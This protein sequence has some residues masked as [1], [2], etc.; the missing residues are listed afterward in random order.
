M[1]TDKEYVDSHGIDKYLDV[2]AV[3]LNILK[4]K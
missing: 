4:T 2:D 3:E 1:L